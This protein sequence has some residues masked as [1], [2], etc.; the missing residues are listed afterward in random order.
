MQE[1]FTLNFC[2][3]ERS[4]FTRKHRPSKK[5]KSINYWTCIYR[6]EIQIKK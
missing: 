6:N 5:N 3:S 1:V 2:G 4:N